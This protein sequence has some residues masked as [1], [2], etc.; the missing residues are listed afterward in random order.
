ML[1]VGNMGDRVPNGVIW[2]QALGLA[3]LVCAIPA[4]TSWHRF[5]ILEPSVA[6]RRI[7]ISFKQEELRYVGRV[8]I[9]FLAFFLVWF[10][11]NL[12]LISPANN[13]LKENA[14]DPGLAGIVL[15]IVSI[16]S[17]TL[18]T[19]PIAG[20]LLTLPAA[21][22]GKSLKAAEAARFYSGNILRL[23][24]IYMLALLP[25]PVLRVIVELSV[26]REG[27]QNPMPIILTKTVLD[28]SV[29]LF[30]FTITVGVL[31]LSYRFLVEKKDIL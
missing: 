12:V 15:A 16:I 17:V 21:A 1:T 9:L 2:S 22:V 11:F 28:I 27:M 29:E 24:A 26:G 19:L 8:L 25:Q 20:L 3:Y 14:V 23:W 31:S 4:I 7:G 30:F 5:I 10:F 18:A 13:L 6:E